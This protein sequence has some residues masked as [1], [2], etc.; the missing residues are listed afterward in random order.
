MLVAERPTGAKAGDR[1]QDY[2]RLDL[3]QAVE[4]DAQRPQY[5]RRQIGD[6][7]IGSREEFFDDL[8]AFGCSRVQGHPEFVAV[9]REK[10]RTATLW[11]GADRDE[12][13]VFATTDPLDANHLGAKVSQQRGTKGSSDITP[14]IEN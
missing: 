8:A 5:L 14:K 4:I 9:H 13:S 3:P 11:P 7:D 1:R 6:D 2:V 12:W 10:H